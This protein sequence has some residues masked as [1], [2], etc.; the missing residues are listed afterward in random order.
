MTLFPR[1][2][3]ISA[4][5]IRM[6]LLVSLTALVLAC[7][8]FFSYD[9]VSF[10][11]SLIRDLAAEARIVGS[12]SVSALLFNDKEAA[13]N[14]LTA[15]SGSH[16]ILGAAIVGNDGKVFAGYRSREGWAMRFPPLVAGRNQQYW[17]SGRDVLLAQRIIFQG[18]S[19]GTVYLFARLGELGTRAR[20]YMLIAAVI[21]LLCLG[22]AMIAT[23]SFRRQVA[24]PIVALAEMSRKVS[25]DR[26]YS[27]RAPPSR[28]RDEV[29]V[30]IDAFNEMLAQIEQRDIALRHAKDELEERVQERTAELK[31]A[32]RELEAFSYT[33]AHDLRGPLDAVSGIG[34]VLQKDYANTM[35]ADGLEMLQSL[36][37]SSTRMATL[38]D[39]LLNLSRAG[40]SGLE[41]S[42]VDLSALATLIAEELQVAEP[43]RKVKFTIAAGAIVL[44]DAGLMRVALENLIR[45][46][47]KYTEKIS[48]ATIEFGYQ[49]SAHEIVCFVRDNGAG[50]NPEFAD[51]LFKP[52]QRL[53][54][55]GEFVGTGIG[56]AT[57]QRIISRH[58]GRVWAEG[59][60]DN[61]ATFYFGLDF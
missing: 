42:T 7:V 8:A 50:F 29:S 59:I 54:T 37:N 45:N 61:G 18:H 60:V 41:R 17:I 30:L 36:R 11:A 55:Q 3:S 32:V 47:W 43:Q 28:D 6:N 25:K 10:Q 52:F 14:T 5:L 13:V 48:D 46:A 20:R 34:F 49:R 39:D 27:L 16:D 26:N 22:T 12:N 23:V 24:E 51:R 33:V 44:A 35:D 57:V 31:T 53:H 19:E 56:L 1:A 21:L 40:T 2:T 9:L 58:G 38:I 15:L 4:K